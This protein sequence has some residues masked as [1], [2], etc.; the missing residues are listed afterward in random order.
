MHS[1]Q[2]H[3]SLNNALPPAVPHP[4]R[5]QAALGNVLAAIIP[6][7]RIVPAVDPKDMNPGGCISAHCQ[8]L[9]QLGMQVQTANPSW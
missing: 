4:C 1:V 5:I 7:A 2:L 6:K 3:G 8:H 9:C